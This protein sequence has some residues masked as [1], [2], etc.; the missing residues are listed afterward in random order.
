MIVQVS[1]RKVKHDPL[2]PIGVGASRLGTSQAIA[3]GAYAFALRRLE[4]C[5]RPRSESC[6]PDPKVMQHSF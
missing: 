2:P 4:S 3:L 6:D 5:C 1:S